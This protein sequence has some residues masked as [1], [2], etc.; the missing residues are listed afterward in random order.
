MQLFFAQF[1]I[2]GWQAFNIF[3]VFAGNPGSTLGI[4]R[5]NGINNLA[6]AFGCFREI[7]A[8]NQQGDYGAGFDVDRKPE[9]GEQAVASGFHDGPVEFYAVL[10]QTFMIIG[11]SG[12]A[13]DLQFQFQRRQIAAL[14]DSGQAR[15][16]FLKRAFTYDEAFFTGAPKGMRKTLDNLFLSALMFLLCSI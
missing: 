13:H 7:D 2:G 5:R 8:V 1:C 16:L 10:R 15:G 14:L 6:V 12:N 3:L 9:I 11:G 4:A